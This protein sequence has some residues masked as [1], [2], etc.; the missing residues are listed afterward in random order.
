MAE[1]TA[2]NLG[3]KHGW[4]LGESGW[5][6]GMEGN[7]FRLDTVCHLSVKDRDLASPPSTPAYGDRYIVG[8]S[9]TGAWAG[10]AGQIAV[11][12]G[13]GWAFYAPRI[14]WLCYIEDEQVLS[15]HKPAGWSAGIAI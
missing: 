15:V 4:N 9:P 8:P 1:L 5:H 14:G 11:F 10:K 12:T 2:P 7:L 6:T 13:S 3:L